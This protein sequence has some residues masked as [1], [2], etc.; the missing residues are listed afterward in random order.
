MEMRRVMDEFLQSTI[1]NLIDRVRRIEIFLA[2]I[3]GAQLFTLGKDVLELI[4]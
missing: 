1:S 3:V 4:K 2:F